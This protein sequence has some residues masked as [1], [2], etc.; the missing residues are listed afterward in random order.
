MIAM[1]II[2]F[3]L[4]IIIIMIVIAQK[5]NE[6]KQAEIKR[7]VSLHKK[8]LLEVDSVLLDPSSVNLS[9]NLKLMIQKRVL[10]SLSQIKELN[11][12]N[13]NNNKIREI[14]FE[15]D[16]LKSSKS[17]FLSMEDLNIPES[18]Q[19]AI[20]LIQ[21]IKLIK[22]ILISEHKLGNID[23]LIYSHEESL[24]S[25]A[26]IKILVETHYSKAVNAKLANKIGSARTS[27][28]KSLEILRNNQSTNEY[29]EEKIAL[30]TEHLS[31]ITEELKTANNDHQKKLAEQ[32]YDEMEVLFT[33]KRKW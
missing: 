31:D 32:E 9:D 23:S 10:R 28:E 3:A 13:L 21:Y 27:F 24:L 5:I 2:I 14:T 33:P 29:F 4:F 20:S 17:V 1:S 8:I 18:D 12:S 30:I 7:V 22:R 15:I 11:N 19:E 26:Q 6:K 25:L 16:K